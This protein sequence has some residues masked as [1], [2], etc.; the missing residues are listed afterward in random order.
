MKSA[1]ANMAGCLRP[2]T[3]PRSVTR[4]DLSFQSES[5]G[6]RHYFSNR[7]G[8]AESTMPGVD[9]TVGQV[10]RKHSKREGGHF[11]HVASRL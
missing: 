5:V 11:E 7:F 6:P 2:P 1:P 10:L 3:H 4:K 8:N 9:P